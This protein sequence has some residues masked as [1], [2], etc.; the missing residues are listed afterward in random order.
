MKK[1]ALDMDPKRFFT[2]NYFLKLSL[3]DTLR[4][5]TM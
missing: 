4:L 2:G 3:R 1:T 5:K